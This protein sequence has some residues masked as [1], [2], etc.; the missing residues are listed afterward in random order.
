MRLASLGQVAL[1]R[2][3][4]GA[5]RSASVVTDAT[6]A[7]AERTAPGRETSVERGRKRAQDLLRLLTREPPVRVH[8]PL[9]TLDDAGFVEAE[10]DEVRLPRLATVLAATL[11][12]ELTD[13]RIEVCGARPGKEAVCER[14]PQV[15]LLCPA[16][17]GPMCV[18]VLSEREVG[19]EGGLGYRRLEREQLPQACCG[20]V[21]DLDDGVQEGEEAQ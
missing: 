6:G 19:A 13:E 4:A 7:A 10:R 18:E 9:R 21:G 5:V 15:R 16:F 3:P 14:D 11:E 20:F 12:V 1:L 2:A 8:V 17:E